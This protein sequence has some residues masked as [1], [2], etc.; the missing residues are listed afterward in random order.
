[1]AAV[2]ADQRAAGAR[3]APAGEGS[4]PPVRV[5]AVVLGVA[6]RAAYE[7]IWRGTVASFRRS[8]GFASHPGAVVSWLRIAQLEAQPKEAEAY[9]P[10]AFPE[11]PAPDPLAHCGR[12]SERPGAALRR[13]RRGR[14]LRHG[15][16][17]VP[18]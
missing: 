3:Q 9:S 7:R 1:M 5:R 14:R 12:R 8:H 2:T 13:R 4:L 16:Q 18:D 10:T 11:G 6:D 17:G 15:G